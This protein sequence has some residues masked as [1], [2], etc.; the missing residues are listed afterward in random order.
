MFL[1]YITLTALGIQHALATPLSTSPFSGSGSRR[2]STM[3]LA[4]VVTP[5][6]PHLINNS[7]IVMLKPGVDAQ[8]MLMHFDFL[9]AAHAEDPLADTGA[10]DGGLKHVYDGPSTK[11]YAGSFSDRTVERIRAQP[12]VD[13]IEQDQIVWASEFTTQKNAP[14]VCFPGSS[15]AS[16]DFS[17][18]Y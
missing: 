18:L 16:R 10:N 9:T 3:P 6:T 7:Y 1:R 12:E 11:G 17:Y 14:W 13:Y 8:S 2:Q 5:S 15:H 4:P